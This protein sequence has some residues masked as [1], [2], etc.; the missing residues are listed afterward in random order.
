MRSD[1]VDQLQTAV[2]EKHGEPLTIIPADGGPAVEARGCWRPAGS[3]TGG[4]EESG[5]TNEADVF[6]FRRRDR[7]A[8]GA[9]RRG[10]IITRSNGERYRIDGSGR[11]SGEL[12]RVIVTE[13]PR[14]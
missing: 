3:E 7:V 1:L 2:F 8:R 9:A 13:E 10:A 4:A 5:L 11:L 12:S 14:R 6:A